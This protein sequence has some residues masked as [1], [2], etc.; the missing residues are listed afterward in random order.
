[1][2]MKDLFCKL[3]PVLLLIAAGCASG[4]EDAGLCLELW[5]CRGPVPR[6]IA[7]SDLRSRLTEEIRR[8]GSDPDERH[9][10]ASGEKTAASSANG[11]LT[12]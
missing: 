9:A 12:N 11:K 6:R 2:Q 1:M 4:E 3:F 5:D 7:A 8:Q 10:P